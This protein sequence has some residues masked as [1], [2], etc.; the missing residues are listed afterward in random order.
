MNLQKVRNKHKRAWPSAWVYEKTYGKRLP[1]DTPDLRLD[2]KTCKWCGGNLKNKR[3]S[4]FC[5]P[6]CSEWYNNAVTW[7]RGIPK[8]PWCVIIRDN[9]ACR[10]CGVTGIWINVHNRLIPSNS[11]LEV[12]HII[13]VKDGGSDHIDNLI[14][15]CVKCHDN[16]HRSQKNG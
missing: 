4:S 11:G 14:T 9:F 7:Q 12:H 8:V 2:S 13:P 5:S 10:E 1:Y 15:L 6:T 3:Q 16:K